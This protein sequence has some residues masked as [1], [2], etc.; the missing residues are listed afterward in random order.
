MNLTLINPDRIATSFLP[1]E[2]SGKHWL[3]DKDTKGRPRRLASIE[4]VDD[5]WFISPYAKTAFVGSEA[6]AVGAQQEKKRELR[7]GTSVHELVTENGEHVILLAEDKDDFAKLYTK[8][9][10]YSDTTITIG[11]EDDNLLTFA[12]EYVSAHHAALTLRDESF[13]L[14]DTGSSN[15]VYVNGRALAKNTPVSVCFGDT[16]FI[17]GLKI[18]I[19]KRFIAFNNPRGLVVLTPT[20]NQVAYTPQVFSREDTTFQPPN[21]ESFY[22]SPRI[23]REIAPK[24]INVE[25]PPAKREQQDTPTILK[26]GPSVGMALGSAVMG[27]NMLSNIGGGEG[28]INYMRII[29]PLG[30]MVVMILG[31]VLW[32]NLSRRY[33]KK[34]A[35]QEESKRKAT[36]AGYLDSI[37]RALL[38]E[39]DLQKEIFEENRLTIDACLER[40]RSKDR[41][42]FDRTPTQLDFLELRIGK[43][44]TPLNINLTFPPEK[45][46]LDEDVLKNL[47]AEMRSQRQIVRDVPLSLNLINDYISGVVAHPNDFY[48]FLRGLV[49][50][51]CTLHAPDEVKIVYIG[52]EEHEKEWQFIRSLAHVMGEGAGFRFLATT[53]KDAQDI[54]LR[55]ERELQARLAQS[56]ERPGDYG[57]YYVVVVATGA[58]DL[59]VDI[60]S[61]LCALRSNKGFSVIKLAENIREL[62]KECRCIIEL[63]STKNG[64]EGIS[65]NPKDASS[66]KRAFISDI[67]LSIEQA[68]ACARDIAAIAFEEQDLLGSLPRSLGLLEMF[69][70]ARV[71]HLNVKARWKDNDPTLSLATPLG[72]D[73]QGNHSLL[74]VH[75]D[76]HGPHGLIAGMTGSGKSETIITYILSMAINYRPDEVSFVLIDYKGGGLAGA[77]DNSKARLPHLA[78]TITNLDGSAITRSLVSIQSELKRRQ[79]LFNEARELAGASTIDIYK[80]QRLRRQGVVSEPCPHLFIVADEFAELKSQQPEF[81]DQL[82]S[83]ARIG[84]SLGV[85]LILATQKPSGVVN[86]QIWSNSRFKVCLKVADAGDSKEMLK[87][88]DAAELT[89]AGRYYLMVGYNEYFAL[90][91]SAWAGTTYHPKESFEPPKDDSV[92]LISNTARPIAQIKP[93]KPGFAQSSTP[94]SVVALDHLVAVAEEEG[95]FAPR[96]WLDPLPEHITIDEMAAKYNYQVDD[97]FVLNPI[98]GELDDPANQRQALLTLPLSEEGNTVVYGSAGSGKEKLAATILC[99]LLGEH[100]AETLNIYIM[101]FGAETLCAFS[102]APQVGGVCTLDDEEKVMRLFDYLEREVKRRSKILGRYGGGFFRYANEY[103]DMPSIL[104][105][106]N[107]IAPF[108]DI[109]GPALEQRLTSLAR[110]CIR[111]GVR[112]LITASASNDIRMRLRQNIGV[113]LALP[114]NDNTDYI[115]VLGSMRGIVPPKGSG[116]GLIRQNE[117]IYEFQTASIAPEGEDEFTAIKSFCSSLSSKTEGKAEAIPTMPE[118]ITPEMLTSYSSGITAT[119]IGIAFDSLE[120]VY[121]DLTQGLI[122]R[123]AAKTLDATKPLVRGLIEALVVQGIDTTV[124]DASDKLSGLPTGVTH[125]NEP[126]KAAAALVKFA[127]QRTGKEIKGEQKVCIIF[128]FAEMVGGFPG[129]TDLVTKLND[130][131][132]TQTVSDGISYVFVSTGA[133]AKEYLTRIY[134]TGHVSK[135]DGIW[136][137]D[138]LK[139]FSQAFDPGYSNVSKLPKAASDAGFYIAAQEPRYLKYAVV[140]SERG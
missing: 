138:H 76:V 34:K 75:E 116:R 104:V 10:F 33:E 72:V 51:I 123:I 113:S 58:Q 28:E 21:K 64:L 56:Q 14:T 84:R 106:L 40:A 6:S 132:P 38:Q 114:L 65:Y 61:S 45:L 15:G 48:P 74:D 129:S 89:D 3:E 103:R 39:I 92:V 11:R 32:P 50:Q 85:H 31:A 26:I 82:I 86:D 71:D 136:I 140:V 7:S 66:A 55:L 20:E 43:G 95:L 83:T 12:N 27:L 135:D 36:Y 8:V 120:P 110:E 73:T 52:D 62:P 77:F 63:S 124:L 98:V 81:M 96:L 67:S 78:G 70:A 29:A 102:E 9:G 125:I 23:M 68:G 121:L 25:E 133:Q 5:H 118:S 134:C 18:I 53:L 105:V 69:E 35:A 87:R 1:E 37:K 112:F 19:G 13:I 44:D 100:T 109:F 126:E 130:S 90:G 108:N 97:P 17:M 30:M 54:S 42:L 59:A 80:Y 47:L 4:A 46:A 131:M 139:N 137:G 22:R 122:T 88:P 93:N 94:E 24:A 128:D 101:D 119:A 111:S 60:L 115:S 127:R 57:V 49:A 99:S 16:V 117:I 91:Q 107:E 2:V 41:R 79:A